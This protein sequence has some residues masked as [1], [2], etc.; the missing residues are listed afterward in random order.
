MKHIWNGIA[1]LALL[2]CINAGAQVQDTDRDRD[3]D[4]DRSRDTDGSDKEM[5]ERLSQDLYSRNPA[6][7]DAIIVWENTDE[8][9]DGTY[10]IGDL[11]Y[12][13]RYDKQGNYV[14]TLVERKWD[15]NV[16][17]GIRNSY[18][19]S[20]YRSNKVDR[21]WEVDEPNRQGYYL[22]FKDNDGKRRRIWSDRDGKFSESPRKKGDY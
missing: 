6:T 3:R 19:N 16:P 21:F 20:M 5:N 2:V 1:C 4:D 14:E 18:Q 22:E 17:S 7:K 8:G 11:K 10:A 13:A 9:Y 15:D 12:M